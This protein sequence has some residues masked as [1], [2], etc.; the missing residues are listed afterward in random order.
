[1]TV[2]VNNET[3]F[4]LLWHSDQHTLH[5][6]TPTRHILDNIQRFRESVG[7]DEI[8]IEV[9]G[10][11]LCDNNTDTSDADYRLLQRWVKQYLYDCHTRKRI[12][13]ILAGTSSHDWEQPEMF[14]LL[15]PKGSPYIKYVDALS[16][17]YI[18]ALDIHVMY[19]P[20]N[21]GNKPK[22]EIY[23]EALALLAKNNLSKVDFIFLHGG[24]DFQL[25][26]VANKH[27][28]LYNASAW[29]KLASKI[30]LSGHIHIPG[31]KY[32]IYCS[33]SFDRLR[34]GEM[35]PKGGYQV[36]F[37]KNDYIARFVEN[38]HAMIYD[39]INI[40]PDTTAKELVRTLDQYLAKGI[41][42]GARIRLS[43]GSA[44]TVNPVVDDFRMAYPQYGFDID[45]AVVDGVQVNEILY[46][47]EQFKRISLTK[48]NLVDNTF[49][50]L[51]DDIPKDISLDYLTELLNEAIGQC[52]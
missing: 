38:P 35:H 8:D 17:E 3:Y 52:E 50:Y 24:F 22:T 47:P 6:H 26:P 30:I 45:N 11:D 39:T 25:P 14:E 51:G 31:H 9:W 27:D 29:S 33:G 20:D 5:P 15:K 44:Q 2:T 34:H 49:R 10:G 40:T 4:N 7:L 36:Y 1:M 46:E 13:R 19:V 32:N 37:N 23:E 48:D 21:F 41:M 12:V 42:K 18:K 28:N 43:G 16:I